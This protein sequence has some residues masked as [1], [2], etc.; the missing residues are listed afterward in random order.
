[1]RRWCLRPKPSGATE[2]HAYLHLLASV[3]VEQRVGDE[4]LLGAVA[5]AEVRGEL[6]AV[7]VHT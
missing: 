1:M 2:H 6:Q 4:L 3:Q 5:L 7:V